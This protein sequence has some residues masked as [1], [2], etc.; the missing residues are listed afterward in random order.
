MWVFFFNYFIEEYFPQCKLTKM[1]FLHMKTLSTWRIYTSVRVFYNFLHWRIPFCKF[2]IM[3]CPTLKYVFLPEEYTPL[4]EL[5]KIM[6]SEYL[7]LCELTK[8]VFYAL[9]NLV[10]LR[11]IH[12]C[13]VFFIFFSLKNIYLCMSWLKWLLPKAYTHQWKGFLI[14]YKGIFSSVQVD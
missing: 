8:I 12:L 5:T 13:H 1:V 6:F 3:V 11:N 9:E 10:Y 14:F 7:P 2:T 4:S